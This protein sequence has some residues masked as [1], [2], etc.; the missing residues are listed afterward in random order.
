MNVILLNQPKFQK[1]IG[2]EESLFYSTLKPKLEAVRD[3]W[4]KNGQKMN[5]SFI[6]ESLE[7]LGKN[8]R[9]LVE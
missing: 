5:A 8:K 2:I 3:I 7:Y 6:C 1:L 9:G 4:E